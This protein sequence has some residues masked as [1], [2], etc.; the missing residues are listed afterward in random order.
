[1]KALHKFKYLDIHKDSDFL[2]NPATYYLYDPITI[3]IK[4]KQMKKM[5]IDEVKYFLRNDPPPRGKPIQVS[6]FVDSKNA[7]DKITRSY[8]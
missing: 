7:G 3:D 6:C 8:Q 1:M 5:Y 4:T 2:F